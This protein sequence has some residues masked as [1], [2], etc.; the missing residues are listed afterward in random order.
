MKNEHYF[1]LLVN[2]CNDNRI[3]KLINV[4]GPKG[5]GVYIIILG[6]LRRHKEYR[7]GKEALNVMSRANRIGPKILKSVLEDFNLFEVVEVNGETQYSSPY[8]DRV[9]ENFEKKHRKRSDAG[10]KNVEKAKRDDNGRFTINDGTRE[11]KKG[12]DKKRETTTGVVV[13]ETVPIN[14]SINIASQHWEE[15]V[16]TVVE[17]RVWWELLIKRT[18]KEELFRR[19][20]R[21]VVE[22]FKQ[23]VYMLGTGENICSESDVKN[24]FANFLRPGTPTY[25][26]VLAQLLSSPA[27]QQAN[28]LY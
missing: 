2:I 7:C 19:N 18:G 23:H 6:E 26:R 12:E 24:Y 10:L 25:V 1:P 9:M 14:R 21:Q 15:Y 20:E 16:D 8:M 28:A 5:Y 17:D 22:A 13:K 27:V 3:A 4:H 11:E